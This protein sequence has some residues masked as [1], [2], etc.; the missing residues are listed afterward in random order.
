MNA[1]AVKKDCWVAALIA[2]TLT[3][4]GV[5]AWGNYKFSQVEA[6]IDK[7]KSRVALTQDG[8]LD[9]VKIGVKA[10]MKEFLQEAGAK[11]GSNGQQKD[12]ANALVKAPA[13]LETDHVLGRVDAPVTM[14]VY[15]DIEC[16]YCRQFHE[17]TLPALRAKYPTDV[18][19]V[20]RHMPL[21]FHAPAA[22][23]EAVMAEC[24]AQIGGDDAFYAFMGAAF[25]T[26]GGNGKG[27][28]ADLP[29]AVEAL[30]VKAKPCADQMRTLPL[31]ES[32]VRSAEQ[33]GVTGTP[34]IFLMRSGADSAIL[35]RGA[36][37]VE[38]LAPRIDQLLKTKKGST[39]G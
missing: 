20:Y 2:A 33:L 35:F 19:V 32:S 5:I 11:S 16:P 31:I 1:F 37:S 23:N 10:G 25:A 27:Y 6:A 3:I 38:M 28:G 36:A 12:A 15:T 22:V 34:T 21:P 4:S 13:V 18:K 14:L 7:K 24:V 17:T 8:T 9:A 29:Q 39:Q 26:T 30:A